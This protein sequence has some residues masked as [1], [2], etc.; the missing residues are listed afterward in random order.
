MTDLTGLT[1]SQLV[2]GLRTGDFT[3][4]ETVQAYLDQIERFEPDLHAFLNL[5]SEQALVQAV[6][7]TDIS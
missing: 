4:R 3:S 7:P 2:H 1:L 5:V 6:L